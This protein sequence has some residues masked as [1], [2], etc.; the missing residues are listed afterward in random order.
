MGFLAPWFL[1][2]VAAVG[3]PV[4]L[5]LLRQHKSTPMPFSSLMFFERRTQSSIKHRRLRHFLLLALRLALLVLLALA[6]ANPFVNRPAHTVG[7]EQLLLVVLDQSFSMRAG[8]RL[9]EARQQAQQ[10]LSRRAAST[11]AQV[12]ALG[13]QL[14]VLTQPTL[15]AG[16]LRAAVESVKGG[17]GR[18]SFGELARAVRSMGQSISTP[19]EVHLFSDMQKTALPAGFSELQMPANAKLILHPVVKAM[20]PNWALENVNAPGLVWDPKKSRVQAT[21]SGYNTG[22][23]ARTVSLVVNGKVVASK[24]VEVPANGRATVEFPSLEVGYGFTRCEVRLD[25]ADGLAQD[26]GARFAVERSDPR[27]VL[28]IHESRDSRSPL[29][30]RS[31]LAS[32]NESAF[33]LEAVPVEQAGNL[34]PS[35]YAFVVLSDV[36]SLPAGLEGELRK[37]VKGGGNVLVTAGTMAARRPRI[38]LFDLAVKEGRYF[39]RS[40]Q[41]FLAVG[42]VDPSHPSLRQS[43]RWE[44]V[45]FYYAVDVDP[46]GARVVARLS[47]QTPLLL[48]KKEGEGRL[49]LLTSGLDNLTNDFPL[50]PIFVSFVEQTARYLSGM[51]NRGGPRMVGS[52]LELRSAREQY[53][54]VEVIDPSGRRALTLKEAAAAQSFPLTSEGFFELRRANGRHEMVAVNADRRESDLSV[55]P[56]ETLS[57]WRGGEGTA[58]AGVA[59]AGGD[60]ETRPV[61]LW[62]YVMLVAAVVLVTESL[63]ASR[64]LAS[65]GEEGAG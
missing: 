22:K 38:P 30:L 48:E 40:G 6:F 33:Q 34:Q 9:A 46:A 45:K 16:E 57:L 31:A 26:D 52:F 41:R 19:I 64:Y 61:S 1:A 32:A 7:G 20:E 44:G 51:E 62:W 17:D 65:A 56:D 24:Q 12:M 2:G 4:Y 28:M 8:S 53:V 39:A 18:A 49:L 29:Y 50:H 60:A 21:V 55:I 14:S 36:M 5:H 43:A 54:G 23:A 47:D 11:R 13:S 27:R 3:L 37:Y 63:F 25:G 58:L 42:Q 35:R 59:G 10:V 15:D